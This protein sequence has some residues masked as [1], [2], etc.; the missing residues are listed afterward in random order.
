MNSP[1][2]NGAAFSLKAPSANMELFKPTSAAAMS[3]FGAGETVVNIGI[4][5]LKHYSK[6]PFKLYTG[7]RLN[8]MVESI[9]ANGIIVPLIVRPLPAIIPGEPYEYEVLA[10]HNRLESGKIAELTEVPCII[11][12]GLTDEE[13]HLIVTETN[14]VQRSFSDL[15]HSERAEALAA[16][17]NAIKHQGKRTDLIRQVEA[18]L[19]GDTDYSASETNAPVG[20]KSIEVTGEK[21]GLSKNSVA[22]YVRVNSLI[23]G[24]KDLLDSEELSI[25]A[26]VSLSYLDEQRQQTVLEQV[27]RYEVIPSMKQA[28]QIRQLAADAPGDVDNEEF[29]L[30]CADILTGRNDKP[31][32]PKKH[33]S[34][35]LERSTVE[36]YFAE[37]VTEETIQETVLAA[38][39]FYHL[40]H[41]PHNNPDAV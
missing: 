15:S 8:D 19:N 10:G 21:Y 33:I 14:L 23:A 6:H 9:K 36:S 32:K 17:Y 27:E 4:G 1:P 35:K 3:L 24:F 7:E 39:E 38:L 29:S 25:R 34:F 18:L 5:K 12:H 40:H 26:G 37:G 22:R 16:H 20:N 31:V 2:K 11:K 30:G 41:A 13:A 28:E